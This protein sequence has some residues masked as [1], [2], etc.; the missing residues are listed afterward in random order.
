MLAFEE[1]AKKPKIGSSL[2]DANALIGG[3]DA[4][5]PGIGKTTLVESSGLFSATFLR[6]D[7]DPGALAPD[8][9]AR[10]L[11]ASKAEIASFGRSQPPQGGAEGAASLTPEITT[12]G[13]PGPV[14][15]E[16]AKSIESAQT[17]TKEAVATA[18]AD[19]TAFKSTMTAEQDRFEAEQNATTIEQLKSMSSTDKRSTLK[20]LGY[21]AK[22]LQSLKDSELDDIIEGKLA[23][24]NRKNKILG[25]DPDE[26]AKLSPAQKTQ[27]LQDLGI[28]RGDLDQAGP[29]RCAQ[30][31][32]DVTRIA[33]IPGQHKVKIQIKSGFLTGKS[34][35]ITVNTDADGNAAFSVEKQGGFFSKLL[36]WIKAA[37]PIILMVLA[38][39]TAGVSLIVLAVYQTVTAIMAGDWLGAI[40]GVI[41]AVAGVSAFMAVKGLTTAASAMT[42]IADVA[43]KV[44]K[45]AQAAQAAM[46]AAKAKDAGSLLGALAAGAAG[47]AA[48][49]SKAA[50]ALAARMN[51]WSTKLKQWSTIVAGGE[52]VVQGVQKGDPLAA[53]A[54]AFDTAAGVVAARG[55]TEPLA[56]QRAAN[57]TSFVATSKR[58]LAKNPADYGAVA[59]AALGIAGELTSDHKLD[60]AAKIVSAA[61]RLKLAW[62]NRE[63]NPAGLAVAGLAV[64][65]A[66]Q[67]AKYDA[68]NEP[69]TDDTGK[70]VADP[71]RNAITQRYTSARL[72]VSSAAAVITAATAKPRPNY[73]AALSAATT[74]ASE[75]GS[76]KNLDAAA[77]IMAKLD[78]WTAAVSSKDE[79]KILA[80]GR[81]LGEVIDGMRGT[82]TKDRDDAKQEAV[83]TLAPG[84]TLADTDEV[85]ELP[86]LDT[87]P[88]PLDSTPIGDGVGIL[89]AV[90]DPAPLPRLQL[91]G[92]GKAS[93]PDGN[94]TVV[95]G[96]T[97]SGIASRFH[98]TVEE[99]LAR[100][101]QLV[102]NM[103][104]ERQSLFVPGADQLLTP[105]VTT[106]T[107]FA[108]DPAAVTAQRSDSIRRAQGMVNT[109]NAQISAWRGEGS[110]GA[111]FYVKVDAFSK[112]IDTLDDYIDLPTSTTASITSRISTL[113]EQFQGLTVLHDQRSGQNTSLINGA[114]VAAEFLRDG[115]GALI[116]ALDPTHRL[117][118]GAYQGIIAAIDEYAKGGSGT[119]IAARSALAAVIE[120][121]PEGK[122]LLG[123]EVNEA[124]RELARA[125]N[126]YM[127]EVAREPEMTPQQRRDL[128]LEYLA[129]IPT[130]FLMGAVKG[131]LDFAEEAEKASEAKQAI[132][133]MLFEMFKQIADKAIGGA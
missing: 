109:M 127:A 56:M 26:R 106:D 93:T 84:E 7:E 52:K 24:E 16:I 123:Q 12:G 38:P 4:Q 25:M 89:A 129:K 18:Q 111:D 27:F 76:D 59:A 72:V 97:L 39:L 115:G 50:D 51:D 117:L 74:L 119:S 17:D 36:G 121:A 108:V 60:D 13:D 2:Q 14:S 66:I 110:L 107:T 90:P 3:Q 124:F 81:A 1:D 103:I 57:I 102:D 5:D 132:D 130:M 120:A 42:K 11:E 133:E 83:A 68:T 131:K 87:E 22:A 114:I 78:A 23:Q 91:G 88:A 32:D 8:P 75:L 86:P 21:D 65:E 43:S 28:D 113:D 20:E 116:S 44:G 69:K 61:N 99:L 63:S 122:G 101:S 95:Q 79:S 40:I 126:D 94:Y 45:V 19:S 85:G 105:T 58:A 73:V 29:G 82:I 33:N 98:C 118:S 47:F 49:A 62:D 100:N 92:N 10:D 46:T 15:P 128:E 77:A 71:D 48:I 34:W 54:G 35:E 64:A 125:G 55:G 9:P 30:C 96:D 37:L 6:A 31:F 53:L 104:Y 41:G 67:T 80:A 112:Q 70:P